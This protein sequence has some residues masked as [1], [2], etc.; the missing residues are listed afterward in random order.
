MRSS[1]PS[2]D[3]GPPV[4]VTLSGLPGSGTSTVARMVAGDLGVDHLDGGTVFRAMAAER[5]LALAAF[6]RLAET[7][8]TIDRTLDDRLARRASEGGVVVESRLAGWL[9]ERGGLAGL[10]VWLAC[11][12][13]ERARRVGARDGHG[14]DDAIAA[15]RA[16][17]ASEQ[18]RYRAYY[19]IDLTDL[20]PYHLVLDSTTTAPAMLAGTIVEAAPAAQG[21]GP[22]PE[23]AVSRP[24]TSGR[25]STARSGRG[26][27]R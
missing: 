3:P 2:P 7:D 14:L 4:L 6:A 11:D 26:D 13:R 9:A 24:V 16:R 12:D 8:D 17:E 20:S 18:A 27:H 10:R 1:P 15:N 23:P 22:R 5:G 19:G 21:E 25:R